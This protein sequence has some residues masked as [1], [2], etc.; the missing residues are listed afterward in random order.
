MRTLGR[1][2]VAGAWTLAADK[3]AHRLSGL[4]L[5]RKASSLSLLE[6]VR[7]GR[8]HSSCSPRVCRSR[9]EEGRRPSRRRCPSPSR[10][11]RSWPQPTCEIRVMV[12]R[13]LRHPQLRGNRCQT[14]GHRG[15][16]R[17][18]LRRWLARQAY[19]VGS[20]NSP[21]VAGN[22]NCVDTRPGTR[23]PQ[24]MFDL[25]DKRSSDLPNLR[26]TDQGNGARCGLVAVLR[27]GLSK[28]VRPA[29]TTVAAE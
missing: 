13:P 20:G 14:S 2:Y 17:S 4:S 28:K 8:C 16:F 19:C 3:F 9:A 22:W 27:A 15:E 21:S 10:A 23:S 6:L 18:A 7:D 12:G 11:G 24:I 29:K 25:Q 26:T 5:Y 1:L